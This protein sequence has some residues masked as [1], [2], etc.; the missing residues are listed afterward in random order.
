MTVPFVR[1]GSGVRFDALVLFTKSSDAETHRLTGAEVYGWAVTHTDARR[2]SSADHVARLQT[3][4]SA[5]IADDVRNAEHHG[6]R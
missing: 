5:E 2:G 4:E 6:P 3:H 1:P